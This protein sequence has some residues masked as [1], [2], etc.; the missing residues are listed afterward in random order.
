M[1]ATHLGA[2]FSKRPLAHL[3][4]AIGTLKRVDSL[5]KNVGDLVKSDGSI[6]PAIAKALH[7]WLA[8]ALNIRNDLPVGDR[9]TSL[10]IP[11]WP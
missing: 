6:G 10:G 7:G 3:D 8:P 11:T 9:V 1:G 2:L 5:P 4:G